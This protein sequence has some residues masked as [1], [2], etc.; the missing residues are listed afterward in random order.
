MDTPHFTC[1][2]E[3]KLTF[4]A[5]AQ[6]S[7]CFFLICFLYYVIVNSRITN[8]RRDSFWS[9]SLAPKKRTFIILICWCGI[10]DK[11]WGVIAMKVDFI[12]VET[13]MTP[14]GQEREFIFSAILLLLI[15]LIWRFLQA[16]SA[17]AHELWHIDTVSVEMFKAYANRDVSDLGSK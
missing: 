1:H 6:Q 4:I 13:L 5:I 15:L 14:R 7:L 2:S 8:L 9:W 3:H 10:K 17:I 16:L 11:A 12:V